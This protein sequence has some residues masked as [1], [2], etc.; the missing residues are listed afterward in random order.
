M[1]EIVNEDKREMREE[2]NRE[3]ENSSGGQLSTRNVDN[4]IFPDN[5]YSMKNNLL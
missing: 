4:M 1:G 2:R 5:Y 3:M